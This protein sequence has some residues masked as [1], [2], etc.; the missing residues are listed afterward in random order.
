M[1]AETRRALSAEK[2]LPNAANEMSQAQGL[3]TC[4]GDIYT[5]LH[6]IICIPILKWKCIRR[7]RMHSSNLV[8]AVIL[9]SVLVT[10]VTVLVLAP[11]FVH[12]NSVLLFLQMHLVC[13]C[14]WCCWFSCSRGCCL[15]AA[16]LTNSRRR[17]VQ[18]ETLFPKPAQFSTK[19]KHAVGCRE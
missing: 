5:F 12:V 16:R 1:H 2:K 9:L 4:Y 11:A 17:L 10:L 14:S 3:Q 19:S 18:Q 8:F 7:M 15:R 13:P 6:N